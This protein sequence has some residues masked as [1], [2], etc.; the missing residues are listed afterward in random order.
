MIFMI[1]PTGREL[2][3]IDPGAVPFLVGISSTITPPC[4][5]PQTPNVHNFRSLGNLEALN[6]EVFRPGST[7][8]RA[9]LVQT[10]R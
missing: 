1:L 2:F 8:E 4:P 7:R 5:G 9:A 10:Q 3:I 6:L